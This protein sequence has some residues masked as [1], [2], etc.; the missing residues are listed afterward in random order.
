MFGFFILLLFYLSAISFLATHFC[1]VS[2]ET[3]LVLLIK[4]VLLCSVRYISLAI[5]IFDKEKCLSLYNFLFL[6]SVY[7]SK[8]FWLWKSKFDDDWTVFLCLSFR[9]CCFSVLFWNWSQDYIALLCSALLS[10]Q[11]YLA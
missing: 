10:T 5:F 1:F 9:F 4:K 2:R 3:I 6:D 11:V 8:Y 7:C